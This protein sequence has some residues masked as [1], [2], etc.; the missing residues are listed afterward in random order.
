MSKNK[1]IK[2]SIIVLVLLLILG[3]VFWV[4][5]SQ[6]TKI[7]ERE[8]DIAELQKSID[9]FNKQQFPQS[10]D[11]NTNNG[12]ASDKQQNTE[13]SSSDGLIAFSM[14]GSAITFN[15]PGGWDYSGGDRLSTLRKGDLII[16]FQNNEGEFF[17]EGARNPNDYKSSY[18]KVGGYYIVTNQ[19]YPN[20]GI[21]LSK[22]E[23][24]TIGC[25]IVLADRSFL[26][27]SAYKYDGP[28]AVGEFENGTKE[29]EEAKSALNLVAETLRITPQ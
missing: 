28:Q 20:R 7:Q 27:V 1:L 16:S 5:S 22:C 26:F 4:Y 13:E 23:P 8:K 12:G 21:D 10:N 25:S 15:K 6:N 3:L 19:N 2:T 9:E 11:S 29:F 17:G 18:Q 24:V 14:G